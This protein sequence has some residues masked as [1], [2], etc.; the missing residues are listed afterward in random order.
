MIR[1]Y[2]NIAFITLMVLGFFSCKKLKTPEAVEEREKWIQSFNDSIKE[3]EII[4]NTAEIELGELNK[5]INSMMDGFEYVSNPRAVDG[6]YIIKDWQKKIPMSKTGIYARLTEQNTLELIATLQGGEFDQI[7]VYTDGEELK[8]SVVK[9]DQALNYRHNNLNTVCFSGGAC[10]SIAEFI[11]GYKGHKIK[12]EF[13]N[14]K[15]SKHI[16]I[17]GDEKDMI[18]RTWELYD[19]QKEIRKLEKDIWISSKKINTYRIMLEKQN[20]NNQ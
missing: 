20:S 10:D 18:A 17:P 4:M 13:L 6:Y 5:T 2:I 19:T 16:D 12:L 9:Y 1:K 15:S 8:S 7:S 11:Y 3:C 14:G